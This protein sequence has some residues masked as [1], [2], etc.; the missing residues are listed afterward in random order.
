MGL[1]LEAVVWTPL[2]TESCWRAIQMANGQ[3]ERRFR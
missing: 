3:M 1:S 2:V